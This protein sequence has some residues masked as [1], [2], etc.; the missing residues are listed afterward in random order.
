[1]VIISKLF[2]RKFYRKHVWVFSSLRIK[3]NTTNILVYTMIDQAENNKYT[4]YKWLIKIDLFRIVAPNT[5]KNLVYVHQLLSSVNT[6]N[7]AIL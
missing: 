4:K 3:L 5:G 6:A 7:V 2:K 1:M